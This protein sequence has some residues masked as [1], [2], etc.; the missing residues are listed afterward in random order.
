MCG[1]EQLNLLKVISLLSHSIER[2]LY[3]LVPQNCCKEGKHSLKNINL[4][5]EP[6][7]YLHNNLE[8]FNHFESRSTI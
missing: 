7:T 6:Y 1:E 3:N 4:I 2:I 5:I 8:P